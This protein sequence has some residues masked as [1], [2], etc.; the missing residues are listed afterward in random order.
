MGHDGV[1]PTPTPDGSRQIW[2]LRHAKAAE[3]PSGGRD[4]DRMLTDRGRRDA[5][6]LGARLAASGRILDTPG[7]IR[8]ELALCSAAVR[9]IQTAELVLADLADH[10]DQVPLDAYRSLY[11][12]DPDAVLTYLR[13]I[14]EHARSVLVVGHNP[15]M[16]NLTW[17]LLADGSPGRDRLE[18]TGLP[19]CALAVVDLGA[20]GWEDVASGHGT[21]LGLFTPPY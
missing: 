8:P 1:M 14:D 5:S 10:E 4:R 2:I 3:A 20:D 15:T 6:A 13:E 21:L 9:T 11:Q 16:S 17:D 19:T 12:A 18:A 7:L